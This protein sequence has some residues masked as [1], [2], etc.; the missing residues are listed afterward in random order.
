MR[1]NEVQMCIYYRLGV[2]SMPGVY[3]LMMKMK[4]SLSVKAVADKLY[5]RD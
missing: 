2:W 1:L 4:V 5:D 3:F